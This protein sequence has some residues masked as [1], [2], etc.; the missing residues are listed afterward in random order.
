MSK[1]LPRVLCFDEQG[2]LAR[3]LE[4]EASALVSL[5]VVADAPAALS[6]LRDSADYAIVIADIASRSAGALDVAR[7]MKSHS[8]PTV[9]ILVAT[10]ATFDTDSQAATS[11]LRMVRK[12]WQPGDLGQALHET[13]AHH[14]LLLNERALREQLARTNA[15]L[16]EKVQDLDEANELLEYWVEFSPAVLYSMSVDDGQLRPS[17]VSK[18][19]H[20]LVGYERTAAVIDGQFWSELVHGDDRGRYRAMLESLTSGDRVV[21]VAEYRVRHRDG[22]YVTILDSVR[23]VQDGDGETVELVGAWLDVSPRR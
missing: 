13:L 19:F 2:E 15:E 10:S 1:V 21:A 8:T 7:A 4:Q 5:T 17:Y 20:R 18:N 6:A 3:A 9:G 16:D 12:P 14:Q 11:V 22:N 23:A